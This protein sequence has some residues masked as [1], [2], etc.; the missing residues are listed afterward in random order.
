MQSVADND[1]I[2]FSR[3]RLAV[4]VIASLYFLWCAYDP[5]QWHLIDGVNLVI[6]RITPDIMASGDGGGG[7]A[8][9]GIGTLLLLNLFRN[10]M[11][12]PAANGEKSPLK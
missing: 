12:L 7:D 5:Y 2:A 4:A 10:Q 11:N 9:G 1:S 3:P 6:Q 8:G